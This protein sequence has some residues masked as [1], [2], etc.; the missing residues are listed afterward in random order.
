MTGIEIG[1]FGFYGF[2]LFLLVMFGFHKY[3]LL[4]LYWKF[5][6]KP[7]HL[8]GKFEKLPRV[9]VQLPIFNEKYVVDRLIRSVCALDYPKDLLEIQLLDD[10][11]DET[12]TVAQNCVTRYQKQGHDIRY[13]HRKGR[14]GFKAGALEYGL[15]TARGE[16]IAIFDADFVPNPLF[17]KE[18]IPYFAHPNVGMVQTRWGHI[19]RGYSLLT[20]I[21]S[22]FLDGH[23][24]IEHTARNRSG[25]FFNFNG[26]AGIWRKETIKSAGGWQH[27]TLT[28]DL[29]L[30]YRAQLAGWDFVFLP[31]VVAPAELPVEMN[32]YKSQQ[33]RWA[34]GS[35]QT[36]KKLLPQIF[37]S[38]IP[39]LVKLEASIHLISNLTYLFMTIPSILM[40]IILQLQLRR[41]WDWMVYLY[42]FVFFAATLSIICYYLIALKETQ[43]SWKQQIPFIPLL[44][45]L[46]IGLSINN[47][48]AVLEA[49]FNRTSDFKRTPKYRIETTHD[50]WR[51]KTYHTDFSFLPVLELMLGSYF[52][53]ALFSLLGE[54]LFVSVPFLILFQFGFVYIGIM[55]FLQSKPF[56]MNLRHVKLYFL[57]KLLLAGKRL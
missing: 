50:K 19:N 3:Y 40:P 36:A 47:A 18:T 54:G 46:G 52:T 6:N 29:D 23:F 22:I 38:D 12:Q 26:T 42:L 43:T 4:Y 28:E 51:H 10:S 8:P 25:K 20:R 49:L 14:E 53:A 48:K 44:M 24:I 33:H 37:K 55:S 56:R 1:L 27:D 11:I 7:R 17:L 57:N 16:F 32:A 31:D 9:T 34:K 41:G 2:I 5:K 13:I 15:K 30:S 35:V 39:F 21:Q 45:S